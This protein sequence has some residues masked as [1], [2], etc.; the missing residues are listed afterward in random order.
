[1]TTSE[2]ISGILFT[3]DKLLRMERLTVRTGPHF[4]DHSWLKIDKDSAWDVLASTGLREESVERIITTADGLIGRHLTIWL[5]TVFKAE[6][7]PASITN[8]KTGLTDMN[9]DRFTHDL[10][11]RKLKDKRRFKPCSTSVRATRDP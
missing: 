4:I 5:D 1:M 6:Q 10:D 7:F 3:T 9:Q 8:L 11:F 2:I